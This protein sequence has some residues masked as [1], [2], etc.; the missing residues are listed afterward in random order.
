MTIVSYEYLSHAEILKIM[1][2]EFPGY[3]FTPTA[4]EIETLQYTKEIATL[5]EMG[6][7]EIGLCTV[8]ELQSKTSGLGILY[9]WE[10]EP[11]KF[12][13]SNE[14]IKA[15]SESG[16]E[17]VTKV[18]GLVKKVQLHSTKERTDI[19]LKLRDHLTE[20]FQFVATIEKIFLTEKK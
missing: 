12:G 11:Q 8:A 6:K 19:T 9:P 4:F 5:S 1:Q 15:L 7:L 13:L 2:R 18:M 3:T 16:Y 20:I 17:R 14:V 10:K